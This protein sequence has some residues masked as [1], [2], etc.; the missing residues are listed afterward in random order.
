[1]EEIK[2]TEE[3]ESRVISIRGKKVLLDR[4]VAELYGVNTRDINKAVSN[5]PAKFPEGYFFT[6]ENAEKREVV[7][8]F[9]R[10]ETLK[11][12]T[13]MPKAFTEKGLYMLATILKSPLA[14]EVTISIIETFTKLRELARAIE[15]ANQAAEHGKIPTEQ[16]TSKFQTMMTDVFK[17][18]LP[19]RLQKFTATVNLGIIKFSAEYSR[20]DKK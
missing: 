5:N 15:D 4:D 13:V 3:V 12:S 14:T 7:E 17:N 10:L 9:H 11:F 6:L 8:K 20:E 19:I 18:P 16:E 1:M 2:K